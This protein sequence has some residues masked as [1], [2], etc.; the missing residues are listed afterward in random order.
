MNG[1]EAIETV[2]SPPLAEAAGYAHD[3]IGIVRKRLRI[4]FLGHISAGAF[5]AP[6]PAS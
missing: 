6:P 1:D 3:G 5:P 4:A 2:L